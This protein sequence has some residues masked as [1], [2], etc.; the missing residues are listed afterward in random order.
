MA[1]PTG[2]EKMQRIAQTVYQDMDF[3]AESTSTA[4]ER[5]RGLATIFWGAPAAQ[6]WARMM[7]LSGSTLSISASSLK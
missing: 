3:A 7:V 6:G 4:T 1:L 5:L 2:E